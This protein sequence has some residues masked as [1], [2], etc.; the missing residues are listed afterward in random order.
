RL[1]V[2]FSRFYLSNQPLLVNFSVLLVSFSDL[3]VSLADLLVNFTLLLVSLFCIDL[4][5]LKMFIIRYK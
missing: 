2:R 3:L 4:F 1:L 5:L